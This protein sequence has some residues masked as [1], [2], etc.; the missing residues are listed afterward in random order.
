[1]E[2]ERK[3]L[4]DCLPSLAGYPSKKITQAYV[5]IQPV[6]RIRQ[7]NTDYFLTVKSQ[8][9]ISREEFEMPITETEY[10]QLLLKIDGIPIE[11]TRF[12]LPLE[13]GYTAELD[14]YHGE[15]L[16]L[17]TVEVEFPDLAAAQNFCPPSWF[18]KDVSLDARYKNN[19]L[20]C[21]GLPQDCIT[22]KER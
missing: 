3:F 8:G 4:V 2:I 14:C 15:L 11:K 13:N 18:G 22:K 1:M 10:E 9:A 21:H 7:M 19:Q 20:A 16:G 5:S 17:I 12:Y 6:I